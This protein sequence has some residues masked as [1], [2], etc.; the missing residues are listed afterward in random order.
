MIKATELRIENIVLAKN[1]LLATVSEITKNSVCCLHPQENGDI[2]CHTGWYGKDQIFGVQLTEEWLDKSSLEKV[3][4]NK[5]AIDDTV[6]IDCKNPKNIF[7]FVDTDEGQGRILVAFDYVHQLQN[8]YS[9]LK[10]KE[11]TL[12]Q[13]VTA[14]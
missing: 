6:F 5:Y 8:F 7:A 1:R 9:A 14:K 2:D 4:E 10:G 3:G 12:T 11:L 13:P